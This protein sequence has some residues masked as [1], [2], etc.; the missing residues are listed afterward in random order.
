MLTNNVFETLVF[1]ANEIMSSLKYRGNKTVMLDVIQHLGIISD[2]AI[3]G[4][5]GEINTVVLGQVIR[6]FNTISPCME[7]NNFEFNTV[8]ELEKLLEKSYAEHENNP[9]YPSSNIDA[10]IATISENA[11]PAHSLQ[12]LSQWEHNTCITSFSL[13]SALHTSLIRG[14]REGVGS[15]LSGSLLRIQ[16]AREEGRRPIVE[17]GMVSWSTHVE[18]LNVDEEEEMGSFIWPSILDGTLTIAK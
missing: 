2:K 3:K 18:E 13:T 14:A 9:R 15:E 8:A 17:N 10:C 12:V 4:N 1:V 7:E 16:R 11:P 6:F 5:E